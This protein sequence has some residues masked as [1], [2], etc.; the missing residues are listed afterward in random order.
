MN[1][2]GV[3]CPELW[4]SVHGLSTNGAKLGRMR[5][6][7]PDASIANPLRKWHQLTPDGICRTAQVS[8]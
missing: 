4:P 7:D 6:Y 1:D 2:R 3:G 5:R 8:F